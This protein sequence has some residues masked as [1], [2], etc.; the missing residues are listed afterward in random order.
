MYVSANT[1]FH[2]QNLKNLV[3]NI[4]KTH[5]NLLTKFANN[6]S[7]HTKKLHLFNTSGAQTVD[8]VHGSAVD[9]S[10]GNRLK[11]QYLQDF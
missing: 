2:L 11:S 10:L 9:F 7:L 5:H 8:K 4:P 3:V 1:L 6:K